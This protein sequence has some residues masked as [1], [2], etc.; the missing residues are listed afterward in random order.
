MHKRL[1]FDN[2]EYVVVDFFD[3][4][5]ANIVMDYVSRFTFSAH[6]HPIIPL[7]LFNLDAESKIK[8][9]FYKIKDLGFRIPIDFEADVTQRRLN[10]YHRFFT[11]NATWAHTY[12]YTKYKPTNPYDKNFTID[13]IPSYQEWLDLIH[14]INTEV[15]RL[16]TAMQTDQKKFVIENGL[17]FNLIDIRCNGNDIH[18]IRWQDLLERDPEFDYTANYA[19][20]VLAEEIQGKSYLRAFLDDDDPRNTDISGRTGTFGGFYIDLAQKRRE[21]YESAEFKQWLGFYDL[22]FDHIP[23]EYPIGKVIDMSFEEN[24]EMID[25]VDLQIQ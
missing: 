20:V 10:L 6:I 4:H 19:D 21:I 16:E 1:V 3:N 2:G 24:S 8:D 17:N 25:K 9:Y 23:F 15:H 14:G 5:G 18:D 13:M 22:N 12:Q 7:H 11:D